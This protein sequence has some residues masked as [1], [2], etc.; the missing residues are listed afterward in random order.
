M[1]NAV[2]D[3][4][5]GRKSEGWFRGVGA[6][7]FVSEIEPFQFSS[8]RVL[9]EHWGV[10]GNLAKK[11]VALHPF[12]ELLVRCSGKNMPKCAVKHMDTILPLYN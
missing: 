11:R 3:F 7:N 4:D 12:C 8:A 9:A 10:G 2:C 5:N 6:I 1:S